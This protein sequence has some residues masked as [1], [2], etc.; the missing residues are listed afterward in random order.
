MLDFK[1]YQIKEDFLREFGF[2]DLPKVVNIVNLDRY[3]CIYEGKLV[4]EAN[5]DDV[6]LV[7]DELFY[8]FNM[9]HPADFTGHSLS[10]SDA[11]LLNGEYYYCCSAGWQRVNIL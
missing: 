7:L 8:V 3:D 5:K 11:V 10:V 4:R 2:M 1:I 6:Y 9:E